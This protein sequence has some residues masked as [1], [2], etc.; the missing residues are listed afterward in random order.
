MSKSASERTGHAGS[1]APIA[2]PPAIRMV[3][4][5]KEAVESPHPDHHAADEAFAVE[6][7]LIAANESFVALSR[8][9][10]LWHD[11]TYGESPSAAVGEEQTVLDGY[12]AWLDAAALLS[13][14][15][16]RLRLTAAGDKSENVERFEAYGVEAVAVWNDHLSRRQA[17]REALRTDELAELAARLKPR[18]A[19][20]DEEGAP[21]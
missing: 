14:R 12:R 9:T 18:Q 13:V 10:D 1:S 16:L 4:A 2:V 15:L 7:L 19:S 5:F 8:F 6:S 11:A 3:L 21:T 20:F 17:E